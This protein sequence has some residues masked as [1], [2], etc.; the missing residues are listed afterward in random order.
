MQIS[1]QKAKPETKISSQTLNKAIYRSETSHLYQEKHPEPIVSAFDSDI[2]SD[3]SDF[4]SEASK[5][6]LKTEPYGDTQK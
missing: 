5:T 2:Y 3:N 1:M 4:T 6:E